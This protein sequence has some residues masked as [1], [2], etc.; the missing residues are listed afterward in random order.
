M[1]KYLTK[2]FLTLLIVVLVGC[3]NTINNKENTSEKENTDVSN[4][5]LKGTVNQNGAKINPKSVVGYV[6]DPM[7]FFEDGVMNVF[8]LQDGRNTYL[9]FHPFALMTTTD[10]IHYKDYGVVIPYVNDMYSQ[11]LALGTGSIIKDKDG[12]YHAFYTGWNGNSN[13]GLPYMEKIQHAISLD[14]INW[15]KLPEDG[16]YGGTNDFRDPYVY[17]DETEDMYHMLITSRDAGHGVIKIYKSSDLS[18]WS[19][20]G[21]FFRN[22][23]GSYN[24]ECPSYFYYNGY[25]Y[26]SYSEQGDH[27]VTHYRYKK[28]LDDPWIK[29]EIDYFNGEGLYAG[30]IEKGFDSLYIFGWCG[31]KT[32]ALDRGGFDWAGSLVVL[33][34]LQQEDGTLL[35]SM[36]KQYKEAFDIE[37]PYK[38]IDGNQESS[39]YFEKD[40]QKAIT[41][42]TLSDNITRISFQLTPGFLKNDCGLTF[43]SKEDD[44]LGTLNIS[45]NLQDRKIYY[46]NNVQSFS[47][48]GYAQIAVPF[49]FENFKPID[50]EIIIDGEII[51]VF[52]DNKIA[53]TTRM[54][55]MVENNF[56]FYS[57][58]CEALFSN[59]KFYE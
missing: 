19:Y 49:Q 39:I 43:N 16:F 28:N 36:P 31:T 8:Y 12:I 53:L 51:T 44:K 13:T 20:H 6:G 54:I 55:A 5:I 37:V 30:R 40:E 25:Y 52:A 18:D 46:F 23:A 10:L 15:V 22:D 47:N 4:E 7:P 57:N 27:R 35:P 59:I 38:T 29:P 21:I 48:Y 11:D 50:I 34:L 14:K 24:M 26:L 1:K 3:N 9:G 32:G 42:E 45:F 17:Y 33:E 2:F 41:M 56:S 58:N